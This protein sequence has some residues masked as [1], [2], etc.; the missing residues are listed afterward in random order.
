MFP[1][2]GLRDSALWVGFKFRVGG[3]LDSSY[4][5]FT[6]QRRGEV[7]AMTPARATAP[8]AA[9]TRYFVS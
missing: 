7:P 4:N 5:M 1:G 3:C 9:R 6:M 2:A 8:P